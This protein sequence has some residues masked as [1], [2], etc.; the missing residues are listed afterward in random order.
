M[1]RRGSVLAVRSWVDGSTK[2]QIT[3]PLAS[4]GTN[5][6]RRFRLVGKDLDH[7]PN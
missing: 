1:W 7:E 4:S 6:G 2:V 5:D 3:V